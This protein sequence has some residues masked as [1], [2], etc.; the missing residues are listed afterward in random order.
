M[1][2]KKGKESNKDIKPKALAINEVKDA[3]LGWFEL[4]FNEITGLVE[5]RK[6]DEDI[7][8]ELNENNLFI[9]LLSN[10]F[11]VTLGNLC[12]L[13]N[14]EFVPSY[15]PFKKYFES[16]PLWTTSDQDYIEI[17]A[18]HVK[19]KDQ[20]QFNHHMKKAMVRMIACALEYHI[21]NKHALILVGGEQNTG[22]STFCRYLCP[23]SLK[24]YY[25]ESIPGDKDGLISLCENFIINLDE[26]STLSKFELN[27]LKSLFSKESV[28]VRHPFARKA[29]TDPRRASF[30]GSTNED[31]FL[32]DTT[33]SVRWLCFEIDSINW[34]YKKIEIDK[35]WSQA[36][37]LYKSGFKFQL[38]ADELKENES[39][40]EQF[41]QLS[42]EYEY[43]QMYFSPGNA[44]DN[45]AFWTTTEIRH[46][47]INKS[48]RKAD[49]KNNDRLGKALRKLGYVPDIKRIGDDKQPTHGYYVKY[50]H[51]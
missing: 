23:P 3:L 34:D 48:E 20:A 18:N 13:L 46:H 27:H 38:S 7:F 35:A 24:N 40:N 25:T 43:V 21:F 30:V 5:G 26:L 47:I 49:I 32:T 19:A 42:S 17:I 45:D 50:L 4:R 14:S 44:F 12:A 9:Q 33:G 31:T 28:R 15:N 6:Q 22:K 11:R 16:L 37:A 29:Q 2:S 39:R 36:Y 10:G 1:N 8:K 51:K 41:Q